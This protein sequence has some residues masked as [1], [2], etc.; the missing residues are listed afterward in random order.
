MRQ[1]DSSILRTLK[2]LSEPPES[3]VFSQSIRTL[4]SNFKQY[5]LSFPV[6]YRSCLLVVLGLY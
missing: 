5:T 3:I 1:Q 2:E 4:A 6:L